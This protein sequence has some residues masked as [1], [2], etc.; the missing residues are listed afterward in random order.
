MSAEE[1]NARDLLPKKDDK[2]NNGNLSKE[3]LI[4]AEAEAEA[5]AAAMEKEIAAKAEEVPAAVS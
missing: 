3:A 2:A 1:L 5:K 4:A